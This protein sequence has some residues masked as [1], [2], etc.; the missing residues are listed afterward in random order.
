MSRTTPTDPV[1][2][3]LGLDEAAEHR[4]D[5]LVAGAG[6]A[7][8]IVARQAA[9]AGGSVLLVD[10]SK[11]PRWKVCGGCLNG[12]ALG[13][14]E[15]IGLGDLTG[16]LNARRLDR[17]RVAI[18]GTSASLPLPRSVAIS[19]EALDT[20][21]V[22]EAVRAGAAFLPGTE[23][24]LSAA[25]GDART[26]RLRRGGAPVSTTARVTV[27]ADGLGGTFLRRQDGMEIRVAPGAP[28]GAG[29]VLEEAPAFFEPGTIF[30]ACDRGAYVGASRLEDGRLDVAAAL[31]ADRL[32][33]S[34]GIGAVVGETMDGCGFPPP[35]GLED[36]DWRGTPPLTRTRRRVAGDRLFV[37]GD[38]A[39]YVEPF[40]GEGMAWAIQAGAL[41]APHVLEGVR[42][43]EPGT[44]AR[45]EARYRAFFRTRK[46]VCVAVSRLLRHPRSARGVVAL[47]DRAPWLASP[48][49]RRTSTPDSVVRSV[50]ERG[51]T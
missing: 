12:A 32:R 3:T 20:E 41:L 8:S 16:R 45:W 36:A 19:R 17:L 9:M 27:A 6:P 35:E 11:F 44:P 29:A 40:T 38:A 15:S 30:M 47:L 4:W 26:V 51:A 13:T 28:I 23:A 5:V 21:L 33:R 43:W 24:V 48:W 7:G 37:V 34:T 25:T 46:R 42:R 31:S 2:A 49:I 39:G 10:R 1:P 22:R 50:V 14:L 18:G